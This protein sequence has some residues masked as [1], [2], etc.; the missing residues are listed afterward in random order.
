MITTLYNYIFTTP[1]EPRPKG[2]TKSKM[3]AYKRS[4]TFTYCDACNNDYRFGNFYTH[5]KTKK[6]LK[7]QNKMT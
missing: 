7:N 6:H 5:I 2:Y 1:D 3:T 4:M